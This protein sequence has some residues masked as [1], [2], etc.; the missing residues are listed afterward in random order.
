MDR[1]LVMFARFVGSAAVASIAVAGCASSE[2]AAGPTHAQSRAR[3]AR[4]VG[5]WRVEQA[6]YRGVLTKADAATYEYLV[7]GRRGTATLYDGDASEPYTWTTHGHHLVL[8]QPDSQYSSATALRSSAAARISQ[9]IDY[10][11]S[12]PRITYA[13]TSTGKITLS[14]TARFYKGNLADPSASRTAPPLAVTA[15]VT[16]ARIDGPPPP[17]STGDQPPTTGISA[18]G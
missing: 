10:L 2:Q 6:A 18:A 7:L 1:S 4:L 3:D 15:S 9:A 14:G 12:S 16:Y 8:Q 17:V 13:V 5:T 11:T